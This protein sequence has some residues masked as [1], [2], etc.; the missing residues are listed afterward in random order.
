MCLGKDNI[1]K[2]CDQELEASTFERVLGIKI[3]PVS[4]LKTA[5]RH[6]VVK[7]RLNALQRIDNF[8]ECSERNL[9]SQLKNLNVAIA[10][11]SGCFALEVN[12]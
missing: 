2:F 5:L 6:D 1:L 10:H 11:L 7:R 8:V 9:S 12:I 3:D 4:I